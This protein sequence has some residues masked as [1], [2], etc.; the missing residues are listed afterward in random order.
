M[1][2]LVSPINVVLCP[3]EI[4]VTISF[5]L[6]KSSTLWGP[7]EEKKVGWQSKLILRRRM[8][9]CAGNLTGNWTTGKFIDLVW[10]SI[11]SPR[12]RV[13]WNGEALGEF[14]ISRGIRQEDPISSYLFVFCIE[15]LS[16]LINVAA[17]QG[18]W[19]PIC[20][21]RGGPKLS[22]LIYVCIWS[23]AFLWCHFGASPSYQ[24]VSQSVL[25]K[26][27]AKG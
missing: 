8:I 21:A 13:I 27:E 3:A 24:I 1:E 17:E 16:R 19:K 10:P 22:H 5:L 14:S 7:R 6:R 26:F 2:D 4:V 18:I 12:M 20:L 9:G 15:R 11:S 25:S 23:C